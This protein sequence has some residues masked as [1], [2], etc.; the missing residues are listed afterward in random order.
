MKPERF[1]A[2]RVGKE[3]AG[4]PGPWATSPRRTFRG[5]WKGIEVTVEIAAGLRVSVSPQRLTQVLLNLLL[6]AA[7]ALADEPADAARSLTVRAAMRGD[8]KVR[9]EVE[10][11]GPG[12]P[13]AMRD[14][15]FDPFMTT[16]DVGSGT[17]LGL[18]VCRGIIEAGAGRIFVDATCTKG[19][20]FVVELPSSSD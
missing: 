1:R 15:I 2:A 10:D 3:F 11:N 17:G 18:A 7:A 12:V 16:K 20:R 4:E 9:I 19:A 13:E 5:K 14:R 6:N 8:A